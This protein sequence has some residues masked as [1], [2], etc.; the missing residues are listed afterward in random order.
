MTPIYNIRLFPM[1]LLFGFV[2]LGLLG[3]SMLARAGTLP[4]ARTTWRLLDYIA[5]DYRGAVSPDGAVKSQSEFA[6]LTEFAARAREGVETLPPGP[7]KKGLLSQVTALEEAIGRHAPPD[8]VADQAHA[9]AA[10][11]L[12]LYPFPAVPKAIPGLS[13]ATTMYE[14]QCS[15]CHG[16]TGRAD[17]AMA[18]QLDPHP[19]AFSDDAR[20]RERSPLALFQT[21]SEGVQGTSM[22]S[23]ATLSEQDRWGLAFYVGQFAYRDPA[24]IERGKALWRDGAKRASVESLGAISQASEAALSKNLGPSDA[25]ALVA[26][27]RAHP[28]VVSEGGGIS[29]AKSKLADS[30]RA[31]QG[32]DRDAASR[33]ALSAYLDGFEPL[34][35]TLRARNADLLTRVE[36]AMVE[37]RGRIDRSATAGELEAQAEI[38]VGLMDATDQSLS[39]A[40]SDAPTAFIGSFTILLREGVE[41]LLVVIAIIAFLRKA[42]RTDVLR[43]VHGGWV[44]ALIAGALTWAAATYFVSISGANREVTEGL[45]SLFAAVVL[46]SVGLWMH[47]KSLAGRWQRYLTERLSNALEQRSAWFLAGLAFISVYREVFE[48]ILFYAALWSQGQHTAVLTGLMAA[49]LVLVV[50]GWVLLRAST[51]LPIARFFSVSSLFIGVLAVVLAGKGAAALQEAGWLSLSVVHFP[52]ISALGLYPTLQT[53]GLQAAVLVVTIAGFAYNRYS[54]GPVGSGKSVTSKGA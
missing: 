23:F 36:A 22:P 43:Y 19:V 21:I 11:V 49:V 16:P 29:L 5:V 7:S 35:P 9:L 6:E 25:Q 52:R 47:H 31:Y 44:G 48:V 32:G 1:R 3:F 53:L 50:I 20:A 4:D 17:T 54:G 13:R 33:L 10:D 40:Q 30:L 18:Q 28:E 12:R 51:R 14:A 45:S 41:A 27:V 34:E 24:L 39:S 37:Y 46:L 38:V 26:Y 42:K 8:G 15:G 2:L